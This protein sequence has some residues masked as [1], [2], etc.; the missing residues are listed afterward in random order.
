MSHID[1]DLPPKLFVIIDSEGKVLQASEDSNHVSF[2]SRYVRQAIDAGD[3]WALVQFKLD[4]ILVDENESSD[5]VTELKEVSQ[6]VIS[7]ST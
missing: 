5:N 2:M 3:G 1:K 4:K 6:N 7:S